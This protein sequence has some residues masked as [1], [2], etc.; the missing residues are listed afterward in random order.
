M[1]NKKTN[2]YWISIADL[3]SGLMVTFMFIAIA[4]MHEIKDIMNGIIYITE[5]FQDTEQSLYNEL[6]KEFKN[7]LE[8]WNAYIDAKTLSIIFK[9]P[10]VLFA[11]GKYEIKDRFKQ[12]LNDFFPRY[13]YVLD[14]DDFRSHIMALRIEGHTSSEWSVKTP[15]REA[16]LNNMTLSQLRASQV[17]NYVLAT[18]LNGK[19]I[20]GKTV[21]IQ[22]VDCAQQGNQESCS[23]NGVSSY[24]TIKCFTK[25]GAEE[26]EGKR[27]YGALTKFLKGVVAGL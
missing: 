9:E 13:V 24:P 6:N 5:G 18:N 16:Y 26:Y 2:G 8:D 12:I 19:Q 11:K 25:N 10:D 20:N 3:M 14:S 1:T 15:K 23:D 17:L 7:E 27:E 21:N 4:Y 22:K